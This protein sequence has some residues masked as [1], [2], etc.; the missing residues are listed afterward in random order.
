MKKGRR[1]IPAAFFDTSDDATFAIG[2]PF[3][4]D[5]NIPTWK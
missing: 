2:Y 3:R 4:N 1:F 5:D